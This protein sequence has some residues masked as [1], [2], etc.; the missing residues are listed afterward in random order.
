[1]KHVIARESHYSTAMDAEGLEHMEEN[2]NILRTRF[3]RN[4]P[5]IVKIGTE[6]G[7]TFV[8]S[9][10]IDVMYLIKLHCNIRYVTYV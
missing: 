4:E 9:F 8:E 7:R 1:M 3:F 6:Y 2:F 10:V 5:F